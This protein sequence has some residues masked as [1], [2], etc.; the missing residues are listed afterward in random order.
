MSSGHDVS[1]Y[2]LGATG[3]PPMFHHNNR[4]KIDENLT[5]I[6]IFRKKKLKKNLGMVP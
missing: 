2:E 3:V 6:I 5:K 1:E 4:D